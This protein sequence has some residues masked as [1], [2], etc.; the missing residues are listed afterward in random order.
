[1]EDVGASL[2]A[3]RESSGVSLEEASKDLSIPVI[4]LEQIEAGAV[5]AFEDIYVLK[6]ELI[7]YSRY[8]GLDVNQVTTEFNEYM[9]DFTSKMSM[10]DIAKAIQEK[11]EEEKENEVLRVSSPYT[12]CY[13]KEKTLPYILAGLGIVILVI[14]A[15]VWSVSQIT[16]RSNKTNVISYYDGGK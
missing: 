7:E 2:K 8:L 4:E 14:L 1:L 6:R 15:V 16:I 3:T 9:F 13:P 12:K 5:G 11:E 10:D